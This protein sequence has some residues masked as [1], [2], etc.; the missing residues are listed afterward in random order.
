MPD[1][2]KAKIYQII[3]PNHPLPYIGSTT[4]PLCKRMVTHRTPSNHCSSRIVINAG[5][6]Y[7]ELIEEYPCE[8]KEQLNRREGEV[9]RQREC[10]NRCIAGRTQTERNKARYEAN[11]DA[12]KAYSKAYREANRDAVKAQ[13]KAYNEANRDAVKAY[14]KTYYEANRDDEKARQKAHY[15]ANKDAINARRRANRA[16]KKAT[17]PVDVLQEERKEDR[18][19]EPAQAVEPL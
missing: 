16:A 17:A 19:S 3:S 11:R 9:I 18:H 15:E 12:E 6:A 5:D 4:Q 10:V 2:A 1:Y 13:K 7:I 8:N 14:N